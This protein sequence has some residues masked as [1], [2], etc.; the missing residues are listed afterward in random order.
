LVRRRTSRLG[1]VSNLLELV[2]DDDDVAGVGGVCGTVGEDEEDALRRKK[3]RIDDCCP[4]DGPAAAVTAAS[5]SNVQT[6]LFA[7][8]VAGRGRLRVV[9]LVDRWIDR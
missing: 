4:L 5:S 9:M 7:F 6:L 2:D 3:L 8:V 1:G